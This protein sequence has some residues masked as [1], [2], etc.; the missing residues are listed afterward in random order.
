MTQKRI[1]PILIFIL[2]FIGMALFS[3]IPMLLF[4][5]DLD[6]LS[7][8][9]RILYQLSCDIGF[10]LIVFTLYRISLVEDFNNYKNNFKDIFAISFKYYIIGFLIMLFSN[11]LISIF[12]S[13]AT[14][15]NEEAV[16]E[17]I[18]LYPVYMV[19]STAVYAPF[20]E[21]IIF[22]KSIR[23]CFLSLKNNKALKYL[24]I[25]ISGFIFA[26]LHVVGSASIPLDYIYIIPYLGLG[27]AF[28]AL[29][30]KTDNI[31]STIVLHSLHNTAAIIIFLL[32]GV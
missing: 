2:L 13:S 29:Y 11:N 30:C 18:K 26:A 12:F 21:E 5:I 32:V 25:G 1:K 20:I 8:K 14:A 19:F 15:Q 23:D 4:K 3:Y 17:L 9:M 27:C 10:M 31:F 22:R 6:S 7:E 24:Y 28:A 16:R